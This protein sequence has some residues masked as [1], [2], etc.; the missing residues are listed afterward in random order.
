MTDQTPAPGIDPGLPRTTTRPTW[1]ATHDDIDMQ[2]EESL[3]LAE[4]LYEVMLHRQERHHAPNDFRA[5]ITLVNDLDTKLRKAQALQAR[6]FDDVKQMTKGPK[7]AASGDHAG[8]A[9][10]TVA[11]LDQSDRDRLYFVLDDAHRLHN[12][13][14]A[15]DNMVHLMGKESGPVYAC[16]RGALDIAGNL[17]RVID[18]VS[19][20]IKPVA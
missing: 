11:E 18:E 20:G 16:V 12:F 2:L 4:A 5:P 14:K 8:T 19:S 7:A 6:Q 1:I 17:A 15:A 10:A 3:G 13:L 9:D